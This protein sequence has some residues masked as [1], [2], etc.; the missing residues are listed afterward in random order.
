[1]QRSMLSRFVG[2]RAFYRRVVTIVLPMII[3]NTVS[4]VVSLLDNVMVGQVGPL[5]MSAV[6][7]INQ[8]MFVFNL[9][10]FGGL[11]GAGIFATQ[12]AGAKD[13]AGVRHCFRLKL[14]LGA[15]MTG[16]AAVIFLVVPNQ[17]ISMYLTSGASEADAAATLAYSL[18]YLRVMLW[19]LLPF[20][21]TQVYAST[22]REI[23]E[24]R[25]PMIA[26]IVAILVNLVFNYLLI[27]GKCGFPE[28]GVVGAAAATVLSRY[29]ETTIIIAY[30]HVKR[31]VFPFIVGAYRSLH[32]PMSLCVSVAKKGSPLLINEFL[33]SSGMAML[34]QCYSLRGL[35]V[36]AATNISSTVANLFNVVFLS[37]GSAVSIM[38]GQALGADDKQGAKETAY[39]LLATAI[40][41]A[42]VMGGIMLVLA[43]MIPQI[44]NVDDHIRDL[45]CQFLRIVAVLMPV[46]S[47]GH[48]CYFTLRSG[49]KTIITFLFDSVF[50]W[51]VCF[52][53][54]YSLAHFTAM[55][56]VPLYFCVQALDIVKGVIGA[57]LVKKGVWIQN[58]VADQKAA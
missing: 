12:F 10:I 9:C 20:A 54:A 14:M 19:G 43:P 1:M 51:T 6:A 57:I 39:K 26:S 4:N 35:D 52:S 15:V 32:V 29:V 58:I 2:D 47:F 44:Y 34:M 8:L 16:I 17:L 46:F 31:H 55:P 25:L 56:I 24:T 13:D 30:T 3:Q 41:V 49:G 45:A 50:T 21:L 48:S 7:I 37:M 18:D 42:V 5:P 28:L 36:V 23:G 33:W 40:G 27:F 38:V 11:A 22:L 53:V